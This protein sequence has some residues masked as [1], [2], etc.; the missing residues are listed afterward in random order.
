MKKTKYY[1]Y[2]FI[3]DEIFLSNDEYNEVLNEVKNTLYSHIFAIFEVKEY[4]EQCMNYKQKS[5][6]ISCD[7]FLSY[8]TAIYL[9]RNPITPNKDVN[10]IILRKLLA[11]Q[12]NYIIKMHHHFLS[13]ISDLFLY[14]ND[15]CYHVDLSGLQDYIPTFQKELK[16]LW[17]DDNFVTFM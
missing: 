3:N 6:M 9:K 10:N 16:D 15:I 13:L 2:R 17:C 5:M 1:I 4:I 7:N 8:E 11:M 14:I 12:K